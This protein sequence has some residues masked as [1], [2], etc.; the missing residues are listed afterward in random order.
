[1]PLIDSTQELAA[2]TV[3]YALTRGWNVSA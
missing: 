3:R 2:A 1:M